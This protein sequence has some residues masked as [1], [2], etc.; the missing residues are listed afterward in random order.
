[1][2]LLTIVVSLLILTNLISCG[3]SKGYTGDKL[4]DNELAIINGNVNSIIVNGKTQKENVLIAKVNQ[5]EVGSYSKGWPK[6]LKVKPGKNEIEVRHFKPWENDFEYMGGGGAIGGLQAGKIKEHSMNHDHYI[7]NFV[8]EKDKSYL[9]NI[10]SNPNDL[11][12]VSITLTNALT[13]EKIDFQSNKIEINKSEYSTLSNTIDN[14]EEL[15]KGNILIYN[16]AKGLYKNKQKTGRIIIRIDDKLL[17]HIDP[18]EYLVMNLNEGKYNFNLLHVD[19]V[20]INS[21]H[22]VVI[23]NDTKVILVKPTMVSNKLEV[24]N[25]LP[26]NFQKFKNMKNK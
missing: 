7:L 21:E 22:E 10:E 8:A 17:G 16:G 11:K 6:N 12:K 14:I 9:I 3:V 5:Q 4:P 24:T 26:K 15:D 18:S 19:V 25:E 23:T 20:N 13:N 1:M 2:R